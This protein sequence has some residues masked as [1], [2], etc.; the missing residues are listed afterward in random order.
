MTEITVA[1]EYMFKFQWQ[2]MSSQ[3]KHNHAHQH[4]TTLQRV[5]GHS[6][7]NLS[8]E[9]SITKHGMLNKIVKSNIYGYAFVRSHEP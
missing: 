3:Q 2:I 6:G 9:S 8:Y 1:L 4:P 5:E 7:I